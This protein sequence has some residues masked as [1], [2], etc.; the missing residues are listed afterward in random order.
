MN[1]RYP[2]LIGLLVSCNR[3]PE[4]I[5]RPIVVY[6]PASCPVRDDPASPRGPYSV[7]YAGGD[8]DNPV[9]AS[10][11]LRDVG[12]EMPAI[13]EK[14]RS[15]IIDVSAGDFSWRG[16]GD[17]PASGP[18]NVLV[19]RGEEACP[20]TGN[21]QARTD[22]AFAVFGH[23]FMVVGGRSPSATSPYTF[24]GDLTTGAVTKLP[25]GLKRS[26]IRPTVT[27][28]GD[29]A[30]VAAGGSD[31]GAPLNT[32]E[33][34]SPALGDFE[35]AAI[36][37]SQ[38][39]MLHGAVQLGTGETLLVGGKDRNGGLLRTMEIVD[40]V[41]RRARTAGVASL[42]VARHSPTVL[43]LA[44]GEVL[45]A[46]G[47]DES[48]A[49][50]PTLEW[51]A[52][53]G[54][55]ATKRAVDLVT[56]QERAFVPLEAG[57]ALAI[58]RPDT[59]SADFK[60]VWIISADG[61]LEPGTA[62]DPMTLD[63]VRLFRGSDGAPIVWTGNRWLKWA[64]WAGAFN[65]LDKA[66]VVGPELDAIDSGDPGL[67]LWVT[68]RADDDYAVTGFR[69]AAHTAFDAVKSPLLS[70]GPLQLAPDRLVNLTGPASTIR[71]D[72]RGIVLDPGASAFVTSVTFADFALDLDV[73][74]SAPVIV[75]RD[76]RG[77]ELEVGGASCGFGQSATRSLHISRNGARV[78]VSADGAA[79]RTCP[80]PLAEGARVSLGVRGA[81]GVT[82]S[83]ARNLR[84]AR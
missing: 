3:D 34:Y 57:G 53:D 44:N 72:E 2:A 26:R 48:G 73:T 71:F 14:A 76:E 49:A 58:I 69:F 59:A 81:Q 45:V 1:W 30:L 10:L 84:I 15:L 47:F 4:V 37:L 51:F 56:G 39:R 41:T 55:Q 23:R 38:E 12:Q 17:V 28:F 31:S 21:V 82:A 33:V 42:A 13:P 8:F 9:Q 83:A 75:V 29:G 52:R 79:P 43:R 11:Y 60:T 18:A 46:G 68:K 36:E 80:T 54:S 7:V 74:A 35:P 77:A 19:W 6:S 61:T 67:A 22:M 5:Q 27:T 66:P 62:I 70:A 24:V 32:A 25:F 63:R 78:D 16:V 50:I 40:P 65:L 20:L 64:P